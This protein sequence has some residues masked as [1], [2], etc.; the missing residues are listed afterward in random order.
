MASDDVSMGAQCL[1]MLAMLKEEESDDP[2]DAA[3]LQTAI[4]ALL[5]W[6][7]GE[8][9]EIGTEPLDE[10]AAMA[11]EQA[12]APVMASAKPHRVMVFPHS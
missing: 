3:L 11:Q 12:Q 6:L 1:S 4:D 7:Q 9:A 8:S 10:Q 2:E 5:A